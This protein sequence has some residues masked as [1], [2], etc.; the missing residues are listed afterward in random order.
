MITQLIRPSVRPATAIPLGRIRSAG[1]AVEVGI[2]LGQGERAE[3]AAHQE[4]QQAQDQDGAG[5][6]ERG[7]QPRAVLEPRPEAQ[8]LLQVLAAPA[9]FEGVGLEKKIVSL[10]YGTGLFPATSSHRFLL[11]S[12]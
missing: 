12:R 11:S 10:Q 6:G 4:A 5:L 7:I 9:A 8:V 1:A 3:H 2:A